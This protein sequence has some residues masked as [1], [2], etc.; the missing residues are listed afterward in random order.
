MTTDK[1]LIDFATKALA[2]KKFVSVIQRQPFSHI[3]TN[4]T[5]KLE[6][7]VGGVTVLL[8]SILKKIGGLM[9]AV[10]SGDADAEVLDKDGH[11]KMPPGEDKYSL[12]RIFL[13][14]KE[15]DR[16]YYGFANQTL[17]PLC[18]CVFVK[19]IF[20]TSWW[21]TYVNI[22]KR[23]AQIILDEIKDDN[24]F[25]WINDYHF[26]LLPKMLRKK[27]PKLNI[28][29]FWHIPWPTSEIFRICPWRKEILEGLLGA[30]FVGFHRR[31]HVENF[32]DCL[33]QELGIQID[34]SSSTVYYQQH[35]TKLLNI[36]T[37]IDIDEI[38]HK[39]Q[40]QKNLDRSFIK[41][42]LGYDINSTYLVVGVDRIDYTKG[43][44]E[45]FRILDRFFDKYP[46][47]Q[48]QVSYL[49]IAV[50]S[51]LNIP[52]VKAYNAKLYKLIDRINSTYQTKQW[53][54]IYFF[55]SAI[56]RDE[57]FSLY[58][59]ADVGLVTPL[60][61]GMNLVAKE[62]AIGAKPNKGV[63]VLSQFAGAAKDLTTALLINPYDVEKSVDALYEALLMN[64]E[65]KL[66]RNLAMRRVLEEHN[67]YRWGM[68]F[69]KNTLYKD[70][71]SKY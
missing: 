18:H 64:S 44:I 57:L 28:G 34:K 39:L 60:D 31:Y 54:P 42:R 25:I 47:M 46:H 68:E 16:F 61:D 67:I 50:K 12:K 70:N 11:I 2:G 17:W 13:T 43:L 29:I 53:K 7:S 19:P 15:L 40:Q 69:I 22:N 56:D 26:A 58:H 10:G 52:A 55:D 45:R 63:L 65:E 66:Q 33:R 24:A 36:P 9:V 48:A 27:R 37:G 6:K 21:K 5:I 59:L 14:K 62:Y 3:K 23:F 51:R 32:M 4:S 20:R 1:D 8:D 35:Q 49:S 30:N 41:K 38:D 71:L